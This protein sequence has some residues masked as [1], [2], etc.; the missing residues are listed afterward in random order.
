MR[1]MQ[2]QNY[3]NW[4]CLLIDDH[5]TDGSDSLLQTLTSEDPRFLLYKNPYENSGPGP[6]SARNFGLSLV[7]SDLVAFC[8]IDDLWHPDKLTIQV[9]AYIRHKA[10]I[11]VTDYAR[12]RLV[13]SLS[14]HTINV[15]ASST[16]SYK[17]LLAKNLLPL[18]TVLMS[19]KF[20]DKRFP[21]IH[22]EDYLYWLSIFSETPSI[23][24]YRVPKVLAYY[25]LHSFNITSNKLLMAMWTFTV[26]RRHGFGRIQSLLRVLR[27][28]ISHL[29]AQFHTIQ[30]RFKLLKPSSRIE[31]PYLS[32]ILH[33]NAS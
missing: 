6:A 20:L 12:F 19:S 5:S 1:S 10:D 14:I 23:N 28:S 13:S 11:V 9:D 30:A 22:H 27:W 16:C 29:L 31:H 25:R 32:F 18:S 33:K 3:C 8:D 2:L 24:Y 21:L 26:F 17:R 15:V 7:T 4:V